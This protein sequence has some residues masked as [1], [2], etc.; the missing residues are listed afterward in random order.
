MPCDMDVLPIKCL[1]ER[2]PPAQTRAVV[3]KLHAQENGEAECGAV[4]EIRL[5]ET[6]MGILGTKF[7]SRSAVNIIWAQVSSHG[8][9]CGPRL[10][11]LG[12]A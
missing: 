9:P 5:L 12:Q 8:I 1:G 3:F 6:K 2:D 7:L 11:A 10:C 4:P